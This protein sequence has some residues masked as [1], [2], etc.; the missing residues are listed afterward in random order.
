MKKIFSILVVSTILF[1]CNKNDGNKRIIPDGSVINNWTLT[2]K[3]VGTKVTQFDSSTWSIS[4]TSTCIRFNY[5]PDS[6]HCNNSSINETYL[7]I[8][9]INS[10]DGSDSL[11]I[12]EVTSS[13]LSLQA[14]KV[15]EDTI[16]YNFVPA[17]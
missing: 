3:L 15:D 9:S 13:S 11:I 7:V 4:E 10:I 12:K 14:T 8:N 1:S 5:E 6:L 17:Q 16:T 2:E